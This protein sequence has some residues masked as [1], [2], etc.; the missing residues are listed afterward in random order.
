MLIFSDASGLT[1]ECGSYVWDVGVED[2]TCEIRNLSHRDIVL[3]W[4]MIKRYNWQGKDQDPAK[5]RTT[6]HI[7]TSNP[8]EPYSC[9]IKLTCEM[10][11][12]GGDSAVYK[13]L[14][15]NWETW[16]SDTEDGTIK[17]TGRYRGS[18]DK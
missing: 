9:D 14:R 13:F 18:Y 5:R 2:F 12:R 10:D 4:E 7:S 8:D 11:N 3:I 16:D 17:M 1:V 15:F 6:P